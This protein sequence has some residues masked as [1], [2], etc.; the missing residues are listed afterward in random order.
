MGDSI[1]DFW[2]QPIWRFFPGK[3]YADRGISAQTTPQMLTDSGQ[4]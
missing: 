1:T 2:Q 3:N 4:T